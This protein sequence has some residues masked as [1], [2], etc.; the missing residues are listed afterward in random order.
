MHTSF[1]SR[2]ASAF[3]SEGSERVKTA[4]LSFK[5]NYGLASL[6]GQSLSDSESDP[7]PRDWAQMVSLLAACCSGIPVSLQRGQR[8][9]WWQADPDKLPLTTPNV[10]SSAAWVRIP[11]PAA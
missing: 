7:S 3:V 2:T 8:F 9:G 11:A 6:S 4:T 5:L 1:D 10:P